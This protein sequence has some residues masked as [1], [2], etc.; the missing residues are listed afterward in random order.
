MKSTTKRINLNWN[1]LVGFNQVQQNKKSSMA[2]IGAK[3][4]GKFPPPEDGKLPPARSL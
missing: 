4:G 3:V 1:K 2:T